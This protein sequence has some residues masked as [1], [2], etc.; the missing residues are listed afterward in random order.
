MMVLDM[1]AE[2]AGYTTDLTRSYSVSGVFTEDQRAIHAA[3]HAAQ[4]AVYAQLKPGVNF[5]DMHRLA[6]RVLITH[7]AK[8]GLLTGGTEAEYAA[9]NMASVFMPHGLGHLLGLNVHDVGGFAPGVE[10]CCEPGLAWVR[11]YRVLEPGMV[12]TVEP[13]IYF[14][15]PW[16]NRALDNPAQ[17]KFIDRAVLKRFET[18]GGVRLEDDI[19]IT[20][21]GWENLS[22]KWPTTADEI[23]EVVLGAQRKPAPEDAAAL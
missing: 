1:G 17:A 5:P 18:F 23:E 15:M 4:Q 13:G 14:N 12:V 3:V 9:A 7:L 22:G 11:C 16:I 8:I 20:E 21:D 10:R 19:L 6:E 2:Y